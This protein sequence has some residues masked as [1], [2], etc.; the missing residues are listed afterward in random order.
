MLTRTE[1]W[2]TR[3]DDGRQTVESEIVAR[4]G[5]SDATFLL[6]VHQI[7]M[8]RPAGPGRY[9]IMVSH[10][11]VERVPSTIAGQ[12]WRKGSEKAEGST[13]KWQV[14]RDLAEYAT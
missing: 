7:T 2:S 11:H 1:N 3:G 10:E 4:E 12:D 6:E 14:R 5:V 13:L 8:A 9:V